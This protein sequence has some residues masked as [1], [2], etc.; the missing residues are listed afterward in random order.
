VERVMHLMKCLSF[1]LVRWNVSLICRHIRGSQNGAADALLKMLYLPSNNPS[2]RITGV[3][4]ARNARLDQ[5][6]LD[7]YV[8]TFFLKGLVDSIQK[9]YHSG[10]KRYLNFCAQAG[11]QGIPAQEAVLC[12]F[13]AQLAT[14]GL[15]YRTIKSYMAGI[16]TALAYRG[17]F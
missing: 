16:K 5:R 9:V 6:K 7:H 15:R 17:R 10:Q 12:K 1:L 11:F 13:V 4:G 14:E 8:Q 3:L 2:R